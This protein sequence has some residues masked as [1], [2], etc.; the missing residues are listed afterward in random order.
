MDQA[1]AQQQQDNTFRVY[2]PAEL[3]KGNDGRRFVRGFCSTEHED[4]EKE[5]VLQDGLDFSEALQFGWFNDNHSKST[6][7]RIGWPTAIEK[8]TTNDGKKGHW[9]EG[10]LLVGYE[11]A[12]RVWKLHEALK[13]NKAPRHLAFSIEGSIDKRLG[14]GGKT[15]AKARVRNIAIT[16]DPVNPFAGMEAVA[17]SLMAGTDIQS[18]GAQPGNAF[19]LRSESLE[20][21]EEDEDERRK[22]KRKR[23]RKRMTRGES[24]DWLMAQGLDFERSVQTVRFAAQLRGG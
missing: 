13:E 16:A 14:P 1:Q 5:T 10:E 4:R 24:I 6:S 2:F 20:G 22:R 19:P 18:P 7:D 9:V 11:P 17:K 8:R 12:D 21:A 23:K 15:I 3:Y